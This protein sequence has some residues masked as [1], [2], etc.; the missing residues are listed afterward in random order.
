MLN[1]HN[2]IDIRMILGLR[3]AIYPVN[4][5]AK[6]KDWYSQVLGKKPYFDQPFYVGFQVGGFELGLLPQAESSTSGPQP[7]WGVTD[8]ESA[9]QKL[10]DLGATYKLADINRKKL[11]NLIHRIFASAKLDIVINDRFGKPVKPREW[12]IVPINVID[13]AVERIKDGSITSYVYDPL[14]AKLVLTK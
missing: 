9:F 13:E 10:V 12:F 11:E 6:A 2:H 5:L 4:D 14:Q 3:T 7:L 1:L 8:I